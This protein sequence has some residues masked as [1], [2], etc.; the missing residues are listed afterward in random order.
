VGDRYYWAWGLIDFGNAT[1]QGCAHGFARLWKSGLWPYNTDEKV[2][3]RRIDSLF[4][5]TKFLTRKDGSL[6]EAF[7]SEGSFCVTALVAFD[8]LCSIDLLTDLLSDKTRNEYIEIVRP[9][10]NFLLKNDESHAIISNHL[11]TAASALIRW[12]LLIGKDV[13]ATDK[14][15]LLLDRIIDHQ[16]TEGW[17]KEYEGADPGYQSLCTHYLADVHLIRKDLGL[18]EPLTSSIR[19][20][21][22]FANPDVSFGGYYGSRSTRFYYPSGVLALANEIPEAR[23]LSTFMADSIAS[24]RVVSLSSMDEPNL[25]P[26]FNSYCWAAV[27]GHETNIGQAKQIRD[28]VVPCES[29]ESFRKD[30]PQAGIVLDRGADHYTIV[31]YRKGGVVQHY[32]GRE[33]RVLDTGVVFENANKRLGSTQHFNENLEFQLNKDKVEILNQVVEMPKKL[34]TPFL[35]LVLR[36]FCLTG[37]RSSSVREFTKRFLVK[38]LITKPKKWPVW[39]Q[40]V[41]S[42]GHE[43]EVEDKHEEVTGYVKINPKHPFVPIHMASKGYW[44]MQDETII[45]GS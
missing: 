19:F 38:Y 45:H 13:K 22:H 42:F 12:D 5:G 1:F 26:M 40:R 16:S 33:M 18:L 10:I 31:N 9:L 23:A 14:A 41:I 43:L 6:E 39:N 7:P 17:F 37:F 25:T 20:L 34:T 3:L 29:G 24:H 4:K 30:F 36:F 32:V 8:L 44:Q 27:L 11:A 15:N 2:F 35:F 28:Y 21:W